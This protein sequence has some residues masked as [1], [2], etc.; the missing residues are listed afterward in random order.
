MRTQH[1]GQGSSLVEARM[2]IRGMNPASTSCSTATAVIV[3]LIEYAIIVV[4]TSISA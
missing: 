2:T 1:G 4:P 3:L